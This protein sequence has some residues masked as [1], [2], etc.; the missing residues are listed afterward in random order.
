MSGSDV[1]HLAVATFQTAKK[2]MLLFS[3]ILIIFLPV[4][5][6]GIYTVGERMESAVR[7]FQHAHDLGHT[8]A[9]YTYAQLLRTGT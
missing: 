9:S 5:I 7:L 8:D 2:C 6:G 1:F 4:S 3:S